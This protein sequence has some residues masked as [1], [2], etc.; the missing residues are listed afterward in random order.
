MFQITVCLSCE[1]FV[2]NSSPCD[3]SMLNARNT[4]K[5][6]SASRRSGVAGSTTQ[7]MSSKRG[8]ARSRVSRTSRSKGRPSRSRL[9]AIR[10]PLKSRASGRANTLPGSCT[11]IG[12][13]GSGPAIA[14][15]ISATSS[16]V[17]AIGPTTGSGNQA[18]KAGQFGTRPGVLRKPTT[19]QKLAGLRSE[20]PRSEPSAS[21]TMPQAS[22]TAAPPLEPPQVR[23]T[24]HGLRVAP[25]T[26]LNV[27]EPAPNSGVLVLPTVMA[28]ASRSR[29]TMIASSSGTK[30]RNSGRAE[31]RA[32]ALGDGEILVRDRQAGQRPDGF[33]ARE[34]G[35]ERARRRLGLLEGARDHRV[36]LRID[37][38]DLRDVGAQHLQGG[39]LAAANAPR[40]FRRAREAEFAHGPVLKMKYTAPRMHSAAHR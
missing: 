9:Q 14:E 7:P 32:D 31:G 28:P 21:G 25:N 5:I 8:T 10:T 39:D 29:S 6:S 27:C 16:T 1:R 3:R 34:P 19:L 4:S 13:R 18:L 11:E 38:F 12:E 40:E 22:A 2:R 24:S 35:I 33:A 26:G 20:P 36:H 15:S 37:A 23:D 17:R 30:S